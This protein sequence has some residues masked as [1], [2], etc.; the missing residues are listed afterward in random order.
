MAT[1]A[2]TERADR[3]RHGLGTSTDRPLREDIVIATEDGQLSWAPYVR[4]GR[5]HEAYFATERYYA[6][7]PAGSFVLDVGCGVG[8]QLQQLLDRGCHGL[9]TEVDDRA[10]A[11]AREKGRPVV[12]APAEALPL[13]AASVDGIVFRAV[14]P[15]TDEH[16]AFAELARVLRPGGR[17]EAEYLGP[18]YGLRDLLL[19]RSLGAR[20]YGARALVNSLLMVLAGR[21]L[22]GKFGD[23][24]YVTP[25]RLQRH[26]ARH[27]FVLRTHTPSPTFLGLPVFIYHAVERVS[28][29]RAGGT[30]LLPP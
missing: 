1:R 5:E 16:R 28:T 17:L 9:G 11:H 23:V 4:D 19:G 24:A 14:L 15:F 20:Y 7:F 10:L 12:R 29:P 2:A 26:Y 3:A 27:G 8:F 13:G 18:G 25:G 21:K 30:D 6:S 22:P